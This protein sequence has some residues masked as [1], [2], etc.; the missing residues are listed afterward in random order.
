MVVRSQRDPGQ[1]AAG[2]EEQ[3]AGSGSGAARLHPDMDQGDG[4]ERCFPT[5]GDDVAGR[6]GVHGRDARDHRH[7]RHGSVLGEQAAAGVGNPHR[8]GRAT[9]EVL[10][11]ALGRALRLLAFGSVAGLVLGVLA[12]RVLAFI[13]YQATPRD[14]LVLAVLSWRCCCWGFWR[15]GSLR[16]GRCP[17]IRLC[18]CARSETGTKGRSDQVLFGAVPG[19][20]DEDFG[21]SS[22]AWGEVLPHAELAAEMEEE[23]RSHI[24]HRADDLAR[25]GMSRA[26]AERRAKIEFGARERF[27]EESYKAVGGNSLLRLG[28]GFS[29]CVEGAR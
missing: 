13:V 21:V 12:S 1:L 5:H 27:R 2:D 4:G 28:Q 6:D 8:A 17:S 20:G 3:A 25:S 22:R 18:C 11:A 7:F 19:V 15:R 29:V 24:E 23:L 9:P 14:P 26:E 10:Q 16:N